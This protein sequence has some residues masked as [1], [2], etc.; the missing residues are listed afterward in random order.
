[1]D[2]LQ[3]QA[4]AIAFEKRRETEVSR[5]KNALA[6]ID[7]GEYGYC[8]DCGEDIPPKRLEIDPASMLCVGCASG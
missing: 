3:Q 6:R 8:E 1:M 4:M 2:A 7:G 5:L